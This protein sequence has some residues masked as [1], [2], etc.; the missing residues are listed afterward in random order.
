M[1]KSTIFYIEKLLVYT[2]ILFIIITIIFQTD[3]HIIT[4]VPVIILYL[5][6][7]IIKIL[8]PFVKNKNNLQA[9]TSN[10]ENKTK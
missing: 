4:I 3:Y 6:F 8:I 10:K 2:I 9:T 5:F 7:V 1:T